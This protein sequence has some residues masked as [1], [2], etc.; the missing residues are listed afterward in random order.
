VWSIINKGYTAKYVGNSVGTFGVL[1]SPSAR[2]YNRWVCGSL[3]A[4]AHPNSAFGGT[5]FMLE[6]LSAI[7]SGI[8][9]RRSKHG[10]I[11]SK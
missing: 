10:K 9:K 2:S 3:P 11:K 6:T 4:V 1:A 8:I 7:G 5:S